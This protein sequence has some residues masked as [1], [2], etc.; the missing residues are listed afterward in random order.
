MAEYDVTT[1]SEYVRLA[2]LA[3]ANHDV[4]WSTN[5]RVDPEIWHSILDEFPDMDNTVV[6]NDYL[7]NDVVDRLANSSWEFIRW[8]LWST[9]TIAA[10]TLDRL[11]HDIEPSVRNSMS[12]RHYITLAQLVGLARDFYPH[13][14]NPVAEVLKE[15]FAVHWVDV[16]SNERVRRIQPYGQ[17]EVLARLFAKAGYRELDPTR[18][19]ASPDWLKAICA[20]EDVGMWA[21][22]SGFADAETL[23]AIAIN[24]CWHCERA[25]ARSPFASASTLAW[26]SFTL[27]RDAQE[28]VAMNPATDLPTLVWLIAAN[29]SGNTPQT[30]FALESRFG[31]LEYGR[32]VPPSP[33]GIDL[34]PIRNHSELESLFLS[35]DIND[36][37]RARFAPFGFHPSAHGRKDNMVRATASFAAPDDLIFDYVVT[38]RESRP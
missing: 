22:F 25:V 18:I 1:P 19:S 16:R 32:P 38:A 9:P 17:S 34:S 30:R 8:Q 35:T 7:P 21:A 6:D 12:L 24:G 2:K 36:N 10:A 20:E 5:V 23:H 4:E 27:N 31:I 28:Y 11:L 14:G 26:L 3:D 13:R 37:V 15:R 29:A 33:A